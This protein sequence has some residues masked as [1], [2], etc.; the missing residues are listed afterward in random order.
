MSNM[1]AMLIG[2]LALFL[3]AIQRLSSIMERT[4]TEKVRDIIARNTNDL[5]RSLVVGA[6]ATILL[7]SSSAVIILT[8]IFVNAR[9]LDFRRAMGIVMGANIGTT[10]GSQIIAFNIFQYSVFLLFGALLV[11][12]IAKSERILQYARIA[13]FLG[14]LFFGLFIIEES[15]LPLKDSATFD[16]WMTRVDESPWMGALI[17]G[18][19]TLIIQSSSAMVGLAIV[20]G[21]QQLITVAGGIAVM[22]GAELGTCA[23]TLIATVNGSRQAI[24]T[25]VFHLLFNLV[26]IILGLVFFYPFVD[27]ITWLSKGESI[28]RHIANA[29]VTF[30]VLGVLLFL[31]FIGWV[32][33]LLNVMI[34]EKVDSV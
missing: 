32:G 22:I 11:T 20:L 17:G 25:G 21:K 2:G 15:V 3:Y 8:I 9:I 30:N 34:P 31:P 10:I 1:I 19:T 29:H 6:L 14:M 23:N 13:L 5:W 12:F 33:K 16:L 26:C 24:K 7:D 28:G 4:F 27:L 18:V